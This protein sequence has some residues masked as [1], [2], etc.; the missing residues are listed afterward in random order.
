MRHQVTRWQ[1]KDED[2]E[3]GS[4]WVKNVDD[5]SLR[6]VLDI[7]DEVLAQYNETSGKLADVLGALRGPDNNYTGLKDRTTVLIRR[8]AFPRVV[9][10]GSDADHRWAMYTD[11]EQIEVSDLDRVADEYHFT[12]HIKW[13]AKALGLAIKGA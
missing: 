3:H 5:L 12:N 9:D 13:A 11:H 7:I 4:E 6:E 1:E 8:A 10:S 2:K